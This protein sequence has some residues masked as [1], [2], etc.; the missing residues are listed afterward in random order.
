VQPGATLRLT[1]GRYDFNRL[2]GMANSNLYFTA[3]TEVRVADWCNVDAKAYVGPAPGQ[4]SPQVSAADIILYVN[5]SSV[6]LP[7][8]QLGPQATIRAN[9]YVPN[10]PTVLQEGTEATGA[11]IGREIIVR[12]NCDLTLN[13]YFLAHP[14]GLLAKKQAESSQESSTTTELPKTFAL[15]QNYPNPFNPTTTIR[16]QLPEQRD[17]NLVVYNMLGQVV[18]TLVHEVQPPGIYNA[19]WDGTNNRGM[20]VASGIY[21]Y[22]LTA[23]GFVVSKKMILLK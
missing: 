6:L 8:V 10:G 21:F 5:G 17:V 1:G 11:F 9:F 15:D 19:R 22:R 3:P 13:S 18:K 23:G 20:S 2:W 12:N 16:Y 4:A 14:D 7:A